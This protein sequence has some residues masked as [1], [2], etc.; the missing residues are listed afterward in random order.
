MNQGRRMFLTAEFLVEDSA[1]SKALNK[2]ITEQ[3]EC[4]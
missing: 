1:V 2:N 4:K 3:G